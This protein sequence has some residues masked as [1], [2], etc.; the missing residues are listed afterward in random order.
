MTDSLANIGQGKKFLAERRAQ[1]AGDLPREEIQVTPPR[2]GEVVPFEDGEGKRRPL[3]ER[4]MLAT[5]RLSQEILLNPPDKEENNAAIG[6]TPYFTTQFGL[7]HSRVQ[8]DTWKRRNGN[9]TLTIQT[10]CDYGL[11]SGSKPRLLL[12][13]VAT[14]QVR[15]PN[16]TRIELGKNVTTF[17]RDEIE[18]PVTGRYIK[19]IRLEMIRLF[20]SRISITIDDVASGLF[21]R[22][23][24]ELSDDMVL[25]GNSQIDQDSLFPSYIV[26]KDKFRDSILD[27]PIPID[28]RALRHLAASSLALD[29]YVWLART[30]F[31]LRSSRLVPWKALHDQFGSLYDWN[32]RRS[33]HSFRVEST[34][35]LTTRIRDVYPT[36]RLT[37]PS[38]GEG[39]IL[40]PSPT[41]VPHVQSRKTSFPSPSTPRNRLL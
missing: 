5:A 14:W 38:N 18:L 2:G 31:S 8:G 19:D 28:L 35:Q 12:L 3:A 36:C 6:F 17:L 10:D 23:S 34:K 30:M 29:Y 33:R 25:W 41:P 39:L 32:D 9:R 22:K 11:P 26:L 4:R 37:I 20:T 16:A 40:H 27:R 24:T 13:W 7:P 21:D 15:H 1:A